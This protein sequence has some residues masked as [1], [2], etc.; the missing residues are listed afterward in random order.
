M[1]VVLSSDDVRSTKIRCQKIGARSAILRYS[2]NI[3]ESQTW[4]HLLVQNCTPDPVLLRI[5][6][7]RQLTTQLCN[8]ALRRCAEKFFILAA[9]ICWIIVSHT[10]A[11]AGDVQLFAE[12]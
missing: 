10:G 1:I 9:K 8:V 2:S 12:H 3:A 6:L 11:G 5:D 4:H 7:L